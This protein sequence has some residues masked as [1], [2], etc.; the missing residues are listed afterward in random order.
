MAAVNG[1][2]AGLALFRRT[3]DAARHLCESRTNR[4]LADRTSKVLIG[5]L[6]GDARPSLQTGVS[7]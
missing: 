6:L 3:D 2:D 7:T 1:A 4:T 5:H